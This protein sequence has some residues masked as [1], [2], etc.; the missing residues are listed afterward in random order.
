MFFS[1]YFVPVKNNFDAKWVV[2]TLASRPLEERKVS[3]RSCFKELILATFVPLTQIKSASL[4]N[5]HALKRQIKIKMWHL[6]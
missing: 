4:L 2:R 6:L 5:I 1:V 3:L